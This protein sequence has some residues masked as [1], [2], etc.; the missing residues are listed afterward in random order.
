MKEL[1]LWTTSKTSSSGGSIVTLTETGGD[2][3][4]DESGY[5]S[6]YC[7]CVRFGEGETSEGSNGSSN[8]SGSGPTVGGN[9]NNLLL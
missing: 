8:S 5:S 3:F 7:R 6:E 1:Q 9:S 2:G 4:N